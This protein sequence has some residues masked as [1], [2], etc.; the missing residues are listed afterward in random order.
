MPSTVLNNE[1]FKK[2]TDR[3]PGSE[4][5]LIQRKTAFQ[6]DRGCLVSYTKRD[7]TLTVAYMVEAYFFQLKTKLVW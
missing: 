6:G 5:L 4:P 1:D 3:F 2:M 7:P